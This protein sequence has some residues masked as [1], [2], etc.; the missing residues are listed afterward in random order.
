MLHLFHFSQVQCDAIVNMPKREPVL[1]S[2]KK[3]DPLLLSCEW[4][5]CNVTFSEMKSFM[6]HISDHLQLL[7]NFMNGE[8]TKGTVDRPNSGRVHQMIMIFMLSSIVIA[9][10]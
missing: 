4:E 3:S 2:V 8:K 7:L 10:G 9:H 6:D 5:A 1:K